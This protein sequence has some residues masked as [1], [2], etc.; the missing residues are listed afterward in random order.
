MHSFVLFEDDVIGRTWTCT[1]C[2]AHSICDGCKTKNVV[3][4]RGGLKYEML[5]E[6]EDIDSEG[7]FYDEDD[8]GQTDQS[9][10]DNSDDKCITDPDDDEE[11]IIQP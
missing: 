3:G 11:V 4:K 6:N 2:T 8:E 5:A 9:D 7:L 1:A 10:G